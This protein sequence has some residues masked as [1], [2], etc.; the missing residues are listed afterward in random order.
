MIPR[1]IVVLGVSLVS[2]AAAGQHSAVSWR[3][4]KI[5]DGFW[6]PRQDALLKTTL[7]QQFDQLIQKKYR[8]NFDRVI[9]GQKGGYEGYVFNDSDVYKVLE[10]AS[11]GLGI[12]RDPKIEKL[13]DEWIEVI[14]KAQMPDGYLNCYFQLMEPNRRWTNLRDQHEMYCAGHLIEAAVAHFQ[15]TNK[16]TFLNV[17]IKLA[18]HMESR[19][20][21]GKKMGYPGHPELELAMMKLWSATGE[22]RYLNF[23]KFIVD[24]RGSKFF[25]NEHGTP[26]DKYDGMYWS[27]HKPIREMDSIEGHAVRAAYLFS[28]VADVAHESRDKELISALDKV[29][30]S[31]VNKR[32]F[33]TG[34]L[35]PS[36]SNEGFTVDY[37]LPTY[38]AYQESCASIANALWNYRMGL[39]HGET[40]YFDVMETAIFNGALAGINSDGD[41]YYYVN[42]LASHGNHHRQD[43]FGCACCPPNLARMIGQMGGLAFSKSKDAVYINLP[44]S[45]DLKTDVNGKGIDLKIRTNYPF[46]GKIKVTGQGSNPAKIFVRTPGWV[47][48]GGSYRLLSSGLKAGES[49]ELNFAMPVRKVISNPQ[50]KD[51]FGMYAIT[52]GPLVYCLE[53]TDNSFD[54]GRSGFPLDA[55]FEV[56]TN[57]SIFGGI[58]VITGLAKEY[59]PLNWKSNL[60]SAVNL[61]AS[62]KFVAIPYF[63]W[64]N[65]PSRSIQNEMMVWLNPNPAPAPI[66][67]VETK[68]QVKVSFRNSNSQPNGV[69]DGYVPATSNPNSPQQLHFWPHSGGEE[70]VE[71]SFDKPVRVSSSRVYWFDDTGRGGVKIPKSWRMQVWT[72]G[73]WKDLAVKSYSLDLDKWNVVTFSPTQSTRFR[74][75]LQQQ[76][77]WSSGIHEWQLF[78]DQ[79]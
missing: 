38:T 66:Q 33:I 58:P 15:A 18:D 55:Q 1:I 11:Y 23:T 49:A 9:K 19:F 34:G 3:D 74:L 30:K 60:F 73:D 2:F 46:D 69:N 35:G 12:Q 54:F 52:R 48:G 70:W 77:K 40:K 13:V 79:D 56:E 68:A 71:Y 14:A 25:A 8:Q 72:D 63:L 6:K 76:D 47:D 59:S 17:A 41:K 22:K 78:E 43:W 50:V 37:D 26:L 28:G 32:M 16:K 7:P 5:Q 4:V 57:K 75:V 21:P 39:L 44:V 24:N 53:K 29:W 42:P 45:A 61:P 31:T 10:A 62:K 20:G 27:D 36:G 67:G 64:D 51:T 65:R